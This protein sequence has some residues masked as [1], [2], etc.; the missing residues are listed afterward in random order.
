M[1]DQSDWVWGAAAIADEIG[2]SERATFYLLERGALPAKRVGGRWAASRSAL[3]QFP[4]DQETH[5]ALP[6]KESAA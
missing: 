5:N 3:R 6:K 2:R 1:N 4:R